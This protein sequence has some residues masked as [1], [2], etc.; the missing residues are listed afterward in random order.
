MPPEY[1]FTLRSAAS[2]S[3]IWLR[4]RLAE[5]T[6]SFRPWPYRRATITRFSRPV[7]ISSTAAA[8][9]AS[10]IVRRTAIGSFTTSRPLTRSV[11]SSGRMSVA[12]IRMKVVLPA[13]FGPRIATGCPAGSSKL[14]SERAVTFPNF[15]LRP[16]A[17]MSASM[18]ASFR[19]ASSAS[20]MW[21]PGGRH[22]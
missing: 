1:V 21:T 8:W 18:R 22:L 7:I 12:T 14:R 11:P 20:C 3:P 9:P 13:P 10:P 19:R 2:S 6:A 4:I 15:F 17:S 5:A 16:R